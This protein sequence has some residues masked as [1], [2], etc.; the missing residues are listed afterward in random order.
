MTKPIS[1]PC[2]HTP[3]TQAYPRCAICNPAIC[4]TDP[5]EECHH[6]ANARDLIE[7]LEAARAVQPERDELTRY[8]SE[9]ISDLL[10]ECCPIILSA[11]DAMCAGE[12]NGLRRLAERFGLELPE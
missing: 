8:I 9:R 3:R 7:K 2:E 4:G 11:E 6:D 10:N 5:G 12:I 1:Q